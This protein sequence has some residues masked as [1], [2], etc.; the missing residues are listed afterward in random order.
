MFANRDAVLTVVDVAS[1]ATRLVRVKSASRYPEELGD[2][3]WSPGADTIACINFA[4][5]RI[6]LAPSTGGTARPIGSG[7]ISYVW[8]PDGARLAY[9][10][11]Y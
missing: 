8:S 9:W 3:E 1:G 7:F 5:G 11:G 2:P 4:T 10:D 6:E